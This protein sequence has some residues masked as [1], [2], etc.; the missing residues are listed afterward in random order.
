[1]FQP[2]L[3]NR[4]HDVLMMS[5]NLTTINIL[6]VH[7]VDYCYIISRI[8]KNDAINLMQNIDLTEK[9]EHYKT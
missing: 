2:G 4:C 1:M 7:V 3:Y 8:R 6:N 5:L 9:A